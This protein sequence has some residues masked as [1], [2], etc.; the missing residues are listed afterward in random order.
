MSYSLTGNF[1]ECCDCFTVCPCWVNDVPDEDHCSGLYVWSL[2]EGS[3]VNGIGVAG[4]HVAAAS[5]HAVRSGGQALFFVDSGA[6]GSPAE[7]ALADAFAGRL[8]GDGFTALGKLLG[9][10]L[11]YRAA[12]ISST[13]ENDN[14]SVEVQIDGQSIAMADGRERKFR[15]QAE[16]MTLRDAAL[17]DELGIGGGAVTIQDMGDLRVDVAAL[18]GGPLHFRGR[19]GLRSTFEYVHTGGPPD[20]PQEDVKDEPQGIGAED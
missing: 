7:R 9:V 17:A 4:M 1:V 16:P 8:G 18:P 10:N 15:Y 6:A 3:T 19:S 20:E 12:R 2:G 11:G 13:F 5:F 14:F